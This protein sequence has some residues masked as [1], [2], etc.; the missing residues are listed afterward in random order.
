MYAPLVASHIIRFIDDAASNP[1]QAA[2]RKEYV[3]AFFGWALCACLLLWGFV[4]PWAAL[5]S[6]TDALALFGD[7]GGWLT[8]YL[9][10][11]VFRFEAD[12]LGAPW[13]LPILPTLS[14]WRNALGRLRSA[15]SAD[16]DARSCRMHGSM[17]A[18]DGDVN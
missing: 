15:R 6:A 3:S 12:R 13:P 16:H 18:D 2:N 11:N 7:W 9:F 8:C 1:R 17:G 10:W 5:H 14:K 4:L